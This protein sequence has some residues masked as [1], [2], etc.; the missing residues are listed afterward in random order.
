MKRTGSLQHIQLSVKRCFLLFRIRD[1][2]K[3]LIV[4]KKKVSVNGVDIYR[5]FPYSSRTLILADLSQT[6]LRVKK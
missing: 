4:T 2:R 6:R 3:Q 1:Y 5:L